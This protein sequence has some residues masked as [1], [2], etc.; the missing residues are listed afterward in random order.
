VQTLVEA[1]DN[2]EAAVAVD[3]SVVVEADSSL[4]VGLEQHQYGNFVQ[5]AP[6]STN[7]FEVVDWTA[8]AGSTI[9]S[10]TT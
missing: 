3:S 8:R 4:V 5:P 1:A 2:P 7:H 6:Q 9:S 10:L